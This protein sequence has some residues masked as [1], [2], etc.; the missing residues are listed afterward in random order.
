MG[1]L[2][3]NQTAR[4]NLWNSQGTWF[5]S[6]VYS[7]LKGGAIGAATTEAEALDDAHAAIERRPRESGYLTVEPHET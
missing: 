4:F 6:L 5:W 1:T 7:D 3:N 2:K